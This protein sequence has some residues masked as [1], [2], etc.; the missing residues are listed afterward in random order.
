M[1]ERLN[2]NYCV[3]APD[4]RGHG[5]SGRARGGNYSI[6]DY[7]LDLHALGEV[8]GRAP[9]TIVAHSLGG[10]I[11]LQY[12]GAFPEKVN[13]IVTIEGMGGLQWSGERGKPA[14]VRMR[15]WVERM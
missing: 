14:H 11:A 7:P 4:L 5:D 9:Y 13:R 15:F 8:I 12:A 3:Y 10:C 1:A 2:A 6:I